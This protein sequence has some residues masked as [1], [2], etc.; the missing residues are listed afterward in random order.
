MKKTKNGLDSAG[1]R[2]RVG[3]R[4]PVVDNGKRRVTLARR[5]EGQSIREIAA[6]VRVSVGVAHKTLNP[7]APV[8]S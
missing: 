5:A 2:G 8:D 7:A 6:A 4:R 3:G 1:A